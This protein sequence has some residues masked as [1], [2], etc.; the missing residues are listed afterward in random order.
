MFA[1]IYAAAT[2]FEA[3]SVNQEIAAENLANATTPGFRR[4]GLVFE[5]Y[6][7]QRVDPND[8]RPAGVQVANSYTN[9]DGGPVQQTSNPLDV[10]IGS[11]AFFVVQGPAGPM[12]TRA[13]TFD[14]T[15]TGELVTKS[16]FRVEGRN[17]PIN[18]PTDQGA[19][20]INEDGEILVA[21]NPVGQLRLVRFADPNELRRVGTSLFDGG[22]P[23]DVVPGTAR[24]QQGYREGSNSDV[25][26]DLV[27]MIVGMR[28]YESAQRAMRMMSEAAALNTRP[29]G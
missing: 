11:D 29:Q 2:A 13:G 22:N 16:G 3:A 24:V 28:H 6:L 5:V 27:G 8:I 14:L 10:A 1:G 23:Q 19:F 21:G 26:R 9:F 7:P 20:Q 4:Q 18:I 12:Y 15:P 17:G 25:V